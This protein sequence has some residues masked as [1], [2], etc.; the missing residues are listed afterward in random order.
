MQRQA[1]PSGHWFKSAAIGLLLALPGWVNADNLPMAVTSESERTSALATMTDVPLR[2]AVGL[3]PSLTT[4]NGDSGG[5]SVFSAGAQSLGLRIRLH[6]WPD[7]LP[8]E[9]RSDSME[10]P[11]RIEPHIGATQWLPDVPGDIATLTWLRDDL[12]PGA[13]VTLERVY[14]GYRALFAPQA[15]ALG[16]AQPCNRDVAC[17][18]AAPWEQPVRATVMVTVGDNNGRTLCSGAVINNTANDNRPLLI[19][20]RHCGVTSANANSVIATFNYQR[21][22]CDGANDGVSLDTISSSTWLGESVSGDTT[23]LELSGDV[24]LSFDAHLGGW[25]A[26]TSPPSNGAGIHHPDGDQKK[27]SLFTMPATASNNVTVSDFIVDAWRI[28]WSSGTTQGGSSGSGLWDQNRRLVGV[29]SGGSHSCNNLS[30]VDFYG[31]LPVAWQDSAAIRNALDPAS[32]GTVCSAGGRDVDQAPPTE[33]PS[34]P[35]SACPSPTPSPNDGGGGGGNA[36]APFLVMLLLATLIRRLFGN[37][38]GWQVLTNRLKRV[39]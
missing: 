18:E 37:V 20:A 24:P 27:I 34:A 8:L 10:R 13:T 7:H 16:S 2:Y 31:R 15:R 5:V 6:Q 28:R 9:W 38:V 1:S 35:S 22:V 17:S 11:H 32:G 29:L 25:S 12:P 23:L 26:E 3:T 30:G 19:T 39:I 21:S 4:I 14:H 36:G 33:T